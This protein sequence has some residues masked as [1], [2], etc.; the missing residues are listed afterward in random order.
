LDQYSIYSDEEDDEMSIS[1][2][3][4]ATK[5]SWLDSMINR[6]YMANMRRTVTQMRM[7]ASTQY[8]EF[9]SDL[10]ANMDSTFESMVAESLNRRELVDFRPSHVLFPRMLRQFSADKAE[11]SD[12]ALKVMGK[13]CDQCSKVSHC[14]LAL[15]ANMKA[16]ECEK[17]CPNAEELIAR[18]S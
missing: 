10:D 3:D 5:P 13:R 18:T 17:F 2:Q 4:L 16:S 1:T 8:Q 6:F 12:G 11:F 14:W 15:R 9:I 7:E